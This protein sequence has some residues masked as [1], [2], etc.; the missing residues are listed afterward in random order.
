MTIQTRTDDRKTM[1]KA[2]AAHLGTEARYQ[3]MPSCAYRVGDFTVNRDGSIDG[4]DFEAIR[5]FLIRE[6]YV[7]GDSEMETAAD[8]GTDAEVITALAEALDAVPAIETVRANA[9]GADQITE[10]HVT[11]P[12]ND[13]TPLGLINLL[14]TLYA[15][16]SLIAAMTKGDLIRIDEELVTRLSDEKP[17]TL[18]EISEILKSEI[19][20]DMVA[21]VDFED[22]KLTMAFAFDE[23]KPTEWTAYSGLMLAIAARARDAKHAGGKRVDPE[24]TEMKYF[25]RNWLIQLGMGGPEF[26]EQRNILLG[27]LH[28]YAAFRTSDKMDAHKAKL[29]AKRKTRRQEEIIPEVT[30]YDPD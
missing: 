9:G 30:V 22:G 21:G 24:E 3:G 16:Q 11:I 5:G 20:A 4:D 1:A 15:R 13:Y 27:H 7:D 26:K 14:R 19:S 23:S 25:C 28:G 29:A 8:S 2:L 12:L 18:R 6:G 17:E 10:T